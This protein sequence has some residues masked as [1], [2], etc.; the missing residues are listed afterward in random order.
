LSAKMSWWGRLRCGVMR[1]WGS[2]YKTSPAAL[3]KSE[4]LKMPKLVTL[5]Q[6]TYYEDEC[7]AD[8]FGPTPDVVLIQTG[9]GRTTNFWYHWIPKLADK[10]RV[11]RRD[12]RGHGR[13]SAPN[14]DTY[15]WSLDTML[16][17]II[18]MLDQLKIDKVH[19][20]GE[21]TSGELGIALAIKYPHSRTVSTRSL[22]FRVQLIFL[23]SHAS[24]WH[25]VENHGQRRLPNLVQKVGPGNSGNGQERVHEN[26][27][28]GI[29]SGGRQRL[30][31][32]RHTDWNNMLC[33]LCIWT[34]EDC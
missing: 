29:W 17:E 34:S 8:P 9:Y 20:V 2:P 19:F 25:S 12:L 21:S 27:I 26:R 6:S 10:Y 33:F 22:R 30:E 15:D 24:F 3:A 14:R 16:A 23:Q 28:R 11:I 5:G 18:D 4:F 1:A 32:V 13:S 31:N 7:Y